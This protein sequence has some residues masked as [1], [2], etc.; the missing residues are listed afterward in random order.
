MPNKEWVIHKNIKEG[1]PTAI[2][3]KV[4]NKDIAFR[5]IPSEYW[6]GL[7]RTLESKGERRRMAWESKKSVAKNKSEQPDGKDSNSDSIP[8][9]LRKK[10]KTNPVKGKQQKTSDHRTTQCYC[11]LCKN[12]GYPEYRY[13]SHSS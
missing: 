12:S 9:V 10:R 8:R 11:V 5:D 2:Q 1:L 7:L 3:E 4:D 6:I 13:K